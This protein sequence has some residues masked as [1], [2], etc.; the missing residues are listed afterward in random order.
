MFRADRGAGS[1]RGLRRGRRAGADPGTRASGRPA[2]TRGGFLD[3]ARTGRRAGPRPRPQGVPRFRRGRHVEERGPERGVRLRCARTREALR[4]LRSRP[5]PVPCAGPEPRH[6]DGRDRGAAGRQLRRHHGAP[7]GHPP[8]PRDARGPE[9]RHPQTDP[10]AR[11]PG[12]A[13]RRVPPGGTLAA[14]PLL[15]RGP[16][17]P[18]G[19][20][21]RARERRPSRQFAAREVPDLGARRPARAPARLHLRYD[22]VPARPLRVLGDVQRHGQHHR[23]RRRRA[24][25]GGRVLLHD[26]F[27]PGGGHGR[28]APVPHAA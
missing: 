14:G 27:E 8:F 4:E 22:A 7:A 21:Q 10:S 20:P 3:R 17:V 19:D 16:A 1:R 2:G 5:G 9:P 13:G 23:R 6:G 15:Q 12:L 24:D 28:V 11:R 25:G 18:R 26:E